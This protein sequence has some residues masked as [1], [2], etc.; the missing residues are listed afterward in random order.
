[1]VICANDFEFFM[2]FSYFVQPIRNSCCDAA[3]YL[4]LRQLSETEDIYFHSHFVSSVFANEGNVRTMDSSMDGA[5]G[6]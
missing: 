4:R 2:S 3:N 6:G 1:M 5:G